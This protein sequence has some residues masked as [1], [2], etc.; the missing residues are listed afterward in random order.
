MVGHAFFGTARVLADLAALPGWDEGFVE[1]GADTALLRGADGRVS[2][3]K[4]ID[5][6]E[7]AFF[8]P[9]PVECDHS[10]RESG[11]IA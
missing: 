3:M 9:E 7:L 1:L 10:W 6:P 11:K 4:R 2:G 8:H 5:A